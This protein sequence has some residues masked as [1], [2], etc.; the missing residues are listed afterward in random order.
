MRNE[1]EPQLAQLALGL[2]PVDDPEHVLRRGG[3]VRR[4]PVVGYLDREALG[5]HGRIG[6]DREAPAHQ[7]GS[8]SGSEREATIEATT[9]SAIAMPVCRSMPWSSSR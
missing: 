5:E 8:G 7:A 1:P 3:V 4:R 9:T 2:A 6:G